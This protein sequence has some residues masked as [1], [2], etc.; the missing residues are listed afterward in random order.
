MKKLLTILLFSVMLMLLGACKPAAV[1][2]LEGTD[3]DAVLAYSESQA[4]NLLTAINNNDFTAFARDF[5]TSM[6]KAMDEKAFGQIQDQ[7]LP[8]IGKYVSRSV[9]K[10]EASGKYRTVIYRAVFEQ[11]D[12][13]TIRLV[14]NNEEE[15]KISGLWLDSTKLRQ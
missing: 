7:L 15:N 10:V 11:D 14:F 1:T 9:E 13:V 8:K 5:D 4:D 3:R 6:A 12:P 2:L